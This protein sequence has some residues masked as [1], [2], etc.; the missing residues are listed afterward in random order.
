MFHVFAEPEAL[1]ESNDP[2]ATALDDNVELDNG[3]KRNSEDNLY[4]DFDVHG[5]TE[6][7]DEIAYD[8]SVNFDPVKTELISPVDRIFEEVCTFFIV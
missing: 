6:K 4:G 3:V 5:N 8:Q 2:F 1:D 7:L